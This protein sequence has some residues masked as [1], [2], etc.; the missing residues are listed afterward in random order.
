ME[1]DFACSFSLG[2]FLLVCHKDLFL[3]V[4]H[5]LSVPLHPSTEILRLILYR[6]LLV[7]YPEAFACFR[8]AVALRF[9][10]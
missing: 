5:S 9:Y 3:S 10:H 7:P 6:M 1:F 8:S 4:T 2:N